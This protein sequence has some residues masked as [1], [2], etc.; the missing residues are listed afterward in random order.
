MN[1]QH[2]YLQQQHAALQQQQLL[3]QQQQAALALQQQ[4]LQAY[5]MNPIMMSPNAAANPG[6][7]AFNPQQL[8]ILGG[9]G[10]PPGV[11]GG[12]YYYVSAADGTPML[13]AANPGMLTAQQMQGSQFPSGI[14]G[15]S[16]GAM[17]SSGM[18]GQQQFG[19]PTLTGM[20][21]MMAF[22]PAGFPGMMAMNSPSNPSSNNNGSHY[23]NQQN[24]HIQFQQR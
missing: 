2:V 11:G 21:G 19:A 18:I 4:Q 24:G 14:L 5:G 9:Q 12:G 13:M 15:Q 1:A 23:S 3:L 10:A 16:P 7:F 17:N 20:S 8:G 6:G 22:P